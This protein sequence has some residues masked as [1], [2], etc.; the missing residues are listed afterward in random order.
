VPACD[1]VLDTDA[2]HITFKILLE[3]NPHNYLAPLLAE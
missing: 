1:V 3:D 2:Q